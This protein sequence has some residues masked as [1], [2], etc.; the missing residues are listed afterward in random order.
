[1]QRL[2]LFLAGLLLLFALLLSKEPAPVPAL[3]PG[4]NLVVISMDTLRADHV[5][6]YGYDRPT[7]PNI[8]AFARQA[9]V[10]DSAISQSAWTRPAH[11]SMFTG[12]YPAEHGVVSMADRL[13]FPSEPPTLASVLSARG[14]R[15][16]AFTGGVNMSAR[17]GFDRGFSVY[18]SHGKRMLD[19]VEEALR[20][21]DAGGDQ[22]FFLFI[23]GFEPHRPYKSDPIDRQA[24]GLAKNRPRGWVR[25]CLEGEVP[26]DASPWIS[27]YDAA[28]HKGDRAV[29]RLLEGLRARGLDGETV[30]V[31]TSDHGEEFF[32][33]GHCYHIYTLYQEILRVPLI[34]RV[35]TLPPGRITGVVPAS[36][37]LAP[38]VLEVLGIGDH[39]MA[40]PS[41]V[42]A[43]ENGEAGFDYVVSETASKGVSGR[44]SGW[45]RSITGDRDKLIDWI[46]RGV[47]EYFDLLQ[48]PQE[49]SALTDARRAEALARRLEAWGRAHPL[50]VEQRPV[51]KLPA[52]LQKQLES[53]GY[54]H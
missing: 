46:E 51:E 18:E 5:G 11:I 54:V 35:P 2:A 49:R 27:E 13:R 23:H 26:E 9:A 45:V 41:L 16:G 38:T 29:G 36:V 15:S 17:F 14:Y 4:C 8:D 31:F 25:R 19:N 48:D 20:W 39:G 33:H 24:L 3:C 32:E 44:R 40:G 10:F 34:L 50:I 7:T 6:A 53:L 47:V 42:S 1:M 22:P 37:S 12:L 52:R 43:L 21:I 30:V 28:V